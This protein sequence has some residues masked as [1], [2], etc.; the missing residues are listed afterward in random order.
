MV[1]EQGQMEQY[2]LYVF[3]GGAGEK[4]YPQS[5]DLWDGE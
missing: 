3:G 1:V 5:A 4:K 2:L